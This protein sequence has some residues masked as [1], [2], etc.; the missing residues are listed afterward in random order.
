MGR[1]W[2]AH[3]P[4][5]RARPA[6]ATLW[7]QTSRGRGQQ[8]LRASES[9]CAGHLVVEKGKLRLV[10]GLSKDTQPDPGLGTSNFS[11]P[12]EKG[13]ERGTVTGGKLFQSWISSDSPVPHPM[14]GFF[15]LEVLLA[16]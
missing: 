15:A 5:A 3:C 16:V 7:G 1:P 13:E 12:I 14:A 11:P 8:G 4:Q 10:S 9:C 2:G 6:V